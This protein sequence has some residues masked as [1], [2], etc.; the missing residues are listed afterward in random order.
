MSSYE[1]LLIAVSFIAGMWTNS[2]IK[3]L[4][5]TVVIKLMVTKD[6]K[7]DASIRGSVSNQRSKFAEKLEKAFEEANKTQK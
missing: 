7:I 1:Y 6:E 3:N 5:L 4:L 2:F